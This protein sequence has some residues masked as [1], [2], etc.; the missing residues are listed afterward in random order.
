[1]SLLTGPSSVAW[2][3]ST[4][5]ET[6]P[7]LWAQFLRRESEQCIHARRRH[8]GPCWWLSALATITIL[9]RW[10]P[11]ARVA[12]HCYCLLAA[13]THD[14]AS[15]AL[16]RSRRGGPRFHKTLHSTPEAPRTGVGV[17]SCAEA[18][19][20][21]LPPTPRAAQGPIDQDQ[22]AEKQSSTC[23][24]PPRCAES[25]LPEHMG[26]VSDASCAW[27]GCYGGWE[28]QWNGARC[29]CSTMPLPP[30]VSRRLGLQPVTVTVT[31][32]RRTRRG[33]SG[34]L[35]RRAAVLEGGSRRGD[36]VAVG[37]AAAETSRRGWNGRL[38][39]WSIRHRPLEMRSEAAVSPDDSMGTCR[40]QGARVR[41][42]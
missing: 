20:L 15:F 32:S 25:P 19:A 12:G 37:F 40:G 29:L 1:M 27:P 33:T 41:E 5:I 4:P 17:L 18:E 35:A 16:L 13:G 2:T 31:V 22:H 30:R 34:P 42:L 9:A 11:T 6:A 8:C 14:C 3:A 38:R 39:V 28:H 26:A 21:C 10:S 36:C 24:P 7:C 23:S